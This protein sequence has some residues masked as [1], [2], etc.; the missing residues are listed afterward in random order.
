MMT[1][2][3]TMTVMPML[4][5]DAAFAAGKSMT[6]ATDDSDLAFKAD[7]AI[8]TAR[9][10]LSAT[11][12]N[13]KETLIQAIK[14]AV[15]ARKNVVTD[16]QLQSII[17]ALGKAQAEYLANRP[18]GW[19]TIKNGN[20]WTAT[21]TG[22]TV[23]AHGPGFIR[24]GDI[25]YMC[26]EDRAAA[27]SA[28]WTPDVNL[29]S[30]VDLVHWKFEK[31]IIENGVTTPELGHGRF[32]ERPKLMYNPK[33]AKYVVWCHYEQGNYGASEAACFE[34][35][36]VNGAYRRVW[37]G[38]PLDTKSRDC[39]VF[40]DDDGT[41]YFISTTDENS[42]LGLFRLSDDYHKAVE[43]SV[44]CPRQ[45]REAPAIVRVD[46]RY[47]MF[48][49]ACSGWEPNQCKMAYTTNLKTGWTSLANVGNHYAYDTQAAA[50]LTIKG[51]KQT[52][53]LYVGDRWQ[54]P[55][56]HGTKT[57]MFPI[58]F[59]GSSVSLDYRE[60]FDINFVTGEWR[61]TPTENVFA[62]RSRF[63]I[64]SKSSEHPTYPAT[65]AI[66]GN[67]NTFWRSNASEDGDASAKSIAI[68]MGA[69]LR[70]KG[71]VITPRLDYSAGLIRKCMIQTSVN[72]VTWNTVYKTD[73]LP[74]W[75]EVT[76]GDRK[77]RY[78]KITKTDGGA[79]S[80]AEINVVLAD[81][82]TGVDKTAVSDGKSREVS[83]V[84]YYN[85]DGRETLSPGKGIY[86]AKVRYKDGH[87]ESTKRAF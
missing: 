10:Q 23:H 14:D 4:A 39:N 61:E 16:G 33:T 6:A 34:C 53:Y 57:I 83:S 74:Y 59:N 70:I 84:R 71:V 36:S 45:G 76:F 27:P 63:R 75:T 82:A 78:I 56:L 11:E 42:N 73:W 80:I 2:T 3:G 49:S 20:A 24:V 64:K 81:Q 37:S 79:A 77:C 7:A 50:I 25:W 87:T 51:T 40:Q 46:N 54:D 86:I 8:R 1:A 19:V 38:R 44:L 65:A 85:I 68:D 32:I 9:L 58:T 41:A 5:H 66:D 60:R 30:S 67:P 18:D 47:F 22:A 17:D 48:N 15:E 72:G 26:G 28:P 12:Y 55:D 52:T 62:D 29:Y 69:Q 31:K 35:D 13:G 43:K 21:N